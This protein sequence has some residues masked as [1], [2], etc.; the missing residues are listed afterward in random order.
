MDNFF[1]SV[2][3]NGILTF[4]SFLICLISALVTGF[5]L[6]LALSFKMK[7]SKRFFVSV[8][9]LP[10]VVMMIITL[11]N[12]N[13]GTGIAVAGAFALVRFRSAPGSAEEIAVVFI[14]VASGLAFGMGF[15]AFG[16]IFT[17]IL[18]VAYMLLSCFNV[19][20]KTK[21]RREKF[22][23]ITIPEDLNYSGVFEKTFEKYLLKHELIKTKLVN[24]GSMYRL[25]FRVT[26]KNYND[27]KAFIDELR[28]LNAN[29]EISL[30]DYDLS[31]AL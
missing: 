27:S 7:A 11:V 9:L 14:T 24:M 8:S 26:V 22:L 4:E 29:L 31:E 15:I 23:K 30:E 20:E 21:N 16:V 2:I 17:V 12:G 10:A 28:L 25:V 1:A 18:A 19:F 3:Q 13:V 6:A 5:G